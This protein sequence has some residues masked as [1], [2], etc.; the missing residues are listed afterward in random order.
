MLATSS[1]TQVGLCGIPKRRVAKPLSLIPTQAKWERLGHG[2]AVLPDGWLV[3]QCY[4]TV[5]IPE[6]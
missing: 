6:S 3:S 2:T 1:Y 4:Q 5:A